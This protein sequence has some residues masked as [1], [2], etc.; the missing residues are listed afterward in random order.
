VSQS[1]A[2]KWLT[3]VPVGFLAVALAVAG[4]AQVLNQTLTRANAALQA[5]E[6]DKALTLLG[7]LPQEGTTV[8]AAQNLECRVR[9]TLQQWNAASR[10]CEQAVRLEGRNS[11][12]HMWLGRTLGERAGRASFLSAYSLGKR[13][14]M[15]FEEATRLDPRNAAALGDLGEFYVEA[16]SVVGG[17]LD[18][19]ESVAEELDRVDPAR[20]HILRARIAEARKDYVKAEQEFKQAV[21]VSPHPAFQWTTLAGYYHH[22]Q[23]W[24]ALDW[25]IS[26]CV[27]AAARDKQ[28]GVALYDGAGVLSEANRNPAL[29]AK[30]LEDYLASSSQ[31]EE[32]PVFVA[33]LRL[34]R[35]EQKLG[36]SAAANKEQ[37]AAFALASEMNPAQGST[38]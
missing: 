38:H 8:A 12:Y 24:S 7:S 25:A 21:A 9:F 23:Q 18:K 37:A 28:A 36:D 26:N 2:V 20:A 29:A 19:A 6:A 32:A 13:V 27:R 1:L 4:S 11:S 5:G 31:T 10:A 15:E 33:H 22:R 17:G 34:A 16:P 3:K 30:M 14:R 35:L